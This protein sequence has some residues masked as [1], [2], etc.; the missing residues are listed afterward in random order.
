M[1]AEHF[2]NPAAYIRSLHYLLDYYSDRTKRTG[3]SGKPSPLISAYNVKM[4]VLRQVLQELTPLALENPQQGLALCD[5][6]WERPYLEFR[7]LA[8]MLVGEIEPDPPEIVLQR[9]EGWLKPDLENFLI[10][11]LLIQ[12]MIRLREERPQSLLKLFKA[13]IQDP[14]IF[15][16]QI[17]LRALLPWIRDPEYDNLPV[18]FRLLQPLVRGAPSGLRPDL[19]DVLQALAQ[20][21]PKETAYFLRQ[22]LSTPEAFDTPWIIRQTLRSF[23]PEVQESLRS[24]LKELER[25]KR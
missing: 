11:A 20:R 23:P 6:L 16:N 8:A 25:S 22:T 21:S 7:L 10:D 17:G 14:D 19:L 9:I 13:W 3:Q 4:P 1:L 12:A 15:Y 5:A 18:F 2:D 24:S